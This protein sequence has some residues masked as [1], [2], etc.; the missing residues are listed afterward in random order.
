M[1][2]PSREGEVLDGKYR[3]LRKLG[4]G[5]MGAVYAGENIRVK[6]SVAIKILHAGASAVAEMADR[7]EREAQAAGQIGNDHICEVHD[8]GMTEAGE[9]Y[10]VMEYLD[11]EPFRT[12]IKR[13]GRLS[14]HDTAVFIAEMLE[15]LEAAHRA[16]IIHRDLK[17]DNVFLCREKAGH[18]DFVKILDFGISK[19]TQMGEAGSMT[20]TGTVMGSPNYMSP[21]HVR[22][23]SEVDAQSDIFS[24]GIM[25]F[26]GMTGTVPRKAPTFAELL[27]KIVYEPMPDP[28]TLVPDLPQGLVDIVMKATSTQKEHRYRSA[29]ELRQA[30]LGFLA[31]ES[32]PRANVGFAPRPDGEPD[33]QSTVALSPEM[34]GA[35]LGPMPNLTPGSHPSFASSQPSL[36]ANNPF[37]ASQPS[38]GGSQPHFAAASQPSFGGFG[39]GIS[40]VT[41]GSGAWAGQAQGASQPSF[42]QAHPNGVAG[43]P[44]QPQFAAPSQPQ[45]G[46]G[47]QP[48]FGSGS[49]P[50]FGSGSQPQFGSSSQPQFGT[51]SQSGTPFSVT[52]GAPESK[53][54]KLPLVLGLVGFAVVAAG[55]VVFAGGFVGGAGSSPTAK[56]AAAATST[57]TAVETATPTA[58]PTETADAATS[59]DAADS[60]APQTSASAAAPIETARP[61]FTAPTQPTIA[62]PIPTIKKPRAGY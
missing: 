29:V 34:A 11:G 35:A 46:S 2:V 58:T 19:F 32:S 21:E 41:G 61:T 28:R 27:F 3:I 9:R 12:R 20:R 59:A 44:S 10:M 43:A 7:F 48:Q 25:L 36:G 30:L 24:V 57:P 49:Q 4:E 45:F 47:S 52:T 23:S 5:G 62:Q 18:R 51:A 17:P 40:G 54:S 33:G 22:A 13:L 60:A 8:L 31:S 42:S 53:R 37:S 39:A 38:M 1:A 16:G 56:P 15:G 6:K 55:I 50:Q 26:E 14:P